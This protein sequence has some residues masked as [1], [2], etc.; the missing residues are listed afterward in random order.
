[1]AEKKLMGYGWFIKRIDQALAREADR[2]LQ[3]HGITMQQSR[4]L[5]MLH[6]APDNTMTLKEL[7]QRFCSAQSTVAG[8]VARTEK[9]G[10]VEG[11]SAQHD[12]RIKCV[13]LTDAGREVRRRCL[14][15]V[16]ASE[17]NLV[18]PLNE[19]ERAQ[20]LKLLQKLHDGVKERQD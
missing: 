18:A 19:E 2:N 15:D 1:M 8:I 10:L 20:L 13:R 12:R 7:E 17:E 9:K 16:F 6:H 5:V 3:S 14:E 4:L 11:F